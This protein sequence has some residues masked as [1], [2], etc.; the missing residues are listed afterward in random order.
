MIPTLYDLPQID[1]PNTPLRPIISSIG[2]AIYKIA[3]A[4]AKILP[5]LLGTISPAHSGDL[6]NKIKNFDT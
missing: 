2:S 4:I 5:H 6:L 1:K 3:R